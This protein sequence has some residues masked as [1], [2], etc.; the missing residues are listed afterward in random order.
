[1]H[2]AEMNRVPSQGWASDRISGQDRV[3]VHLDDSVFTGRTHE[4]FRD[5][6]DGDPVAVYLVTMSFDVGTPF[7]HPEEILASGRTVTGQLDLMES[8]VREP[9][10]MLPAATSLWVRR[11]QPPPGE[12]TNSA[13]FARVLGGSDLL[14]AALWRRYPATIRN[15]RAAAGPGRIRQPDLA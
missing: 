14:M 11:K 1:V 9:G 4:L 13:V 15:R 3:V 7:N 10:G 2:E 6:I 8:L 5:R 12:S